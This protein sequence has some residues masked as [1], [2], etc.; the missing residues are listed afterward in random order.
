MKL[1]KYLC[2][3][4]ISGLLLSVYAF[5]APTTLSSYFAEKDITL[6][7]KADVGKYIL[8]GEF[9]GTDSRLGISYDTEYVYVAAILAEDYDSLS[10]TLGEKTVVYNIAD[11]TFDG[12]LSASTSAVSGDGLELKLSMG[13]FGMTFIPADM[14]Y[15]FGA[16]LTKGEKSVSLSETKAEFRY[17]NAIWY[18]NCED[19]ANKGSIDGASAS[20]AQNIYIGQSE[21]T[22][23]AY[24]FKMINNVNS[25][26]NI[27]NPLKGYTVG[28]AV[29][30]MNLKVNNLPDITSDNLR[31]WRGFVF[32][33][34][35]V[36]RRRFSLTADANGN[37]IG[38][39][40]R[41]SP[42]SN[43]GTSE[44]VDIGKN[45]GDAFKLTGRYN[46]DNDLA[47]Y[48]DDVLVHTFEKIDMPANY[49]KTVYI[50]EADYYNVKSGSIDVEM[51]DFAMC[52]PREGL[53]AVNFESIKGN[54]ISETDI[55][56]DLELYDSIT[57]LG[58]TY[59][60]TWKSSD[61]SIIT[62]DGKVVVIAA[63]AGKE[64]V[65]TAKVLFGETELTREIPLKISADLSAPMMYAY[66]KNET[67]TVDG[68][69]SDSVVFLNTELSGSDAAAGAVWTVDGIVFGINTGTVNASTVAVKLGGKS[70]TYSF[71]NN[72]F[73]ETVQDVSAAKGTGMVEMFIPYAAFDSEFS[74]GERTLPFAVS[75]SDGTN[76]YTAKEKFL[77][78][79]SAVMGS[80]DNCDKFE[81]NAYGTY[82]LYGAYSDIVRTQ[83]SGYYNFKHTST[84][85]AIYGFG[86]SNNGLRNAPFE[87]EVGLKVT[88][89]PVIS[90]EKLGAWR[91]LAFDLSDTASTRH[92]FSLTAS[93][94]GK[95]MF[96]ALY[97]D[98]GD[99]NGL[100][101][102]LDTGK[103]L[104]DSFN[105]RV[106][107]GTDGCPIIYID[108]RRVGSLPKV[109]YPAKNTHPYLEIN[110]AYCDASS[111]GIDVD[112]YD[113][114]L[115]RRKYLMDNLTFDD[116]KGNNPDADNVSMNLALPSSVKFADSGVEVPLTWTSSNE[117]YIGSDGV[118]TYSGESV[119]KT[120]TMTATAVSGGVTMT[121]SFDVTLK[122]ETVDKE[123]YF[124]FDDKN[125]YTGVLTKTNINFEY[126]FDKTENSI[127]LD[128]G[129]KTRIN[130]V[131]IIDSD[132]INKLHRS[133]VSLYVSDDNVN[134]TRIKD[135]DLFRT[136][137]KL[138]FAN[139]E[140]EARF[141]KV[142]CHIA[143]NESVSFKNSLD[144]II[145]ASYNDS[146]VGSGDGNFEKLGSVKLK[147]SADISDGTAYLTFEEMGIDTA[148]LKGDKSDIR[149]A[150]GERTLRHCVEDDG[151]YIRIPEAEAG[152]SVAVDIYGGNENAEN[153]SDADAVFEV[154]Y[155]NRT[156]QNLTDEEN[157]F[158]NVIST[159]RC[160]NGDILAI[161]SKGVVKSTL[162]MRRSTDGG[163]T[164]GEAELFRDNGTTADGFA[165]LV[166][167][168][169]IFCIFHM[170]PIPAVSY[171]TLNIAILVSD[172]NGYTWKNPNT[173]GTD[174]YFPVTGMHYTVTYCEGIKLSTFDGAD[175]DGIDYIFMYEMTS[176]N[177]YS[178]FAVG[179]LY[180][181]DAGK[182]WINSES[183][184]RFNVGDETANHETG[185]SE[186]SVVEL[187]DGTL[188]IYARVQYED[189][190]FLGTS[191]SKDHGVTWDEDCKLTTI[192]S[193]NTHPVLKK[194]KDSILLL[195]AGN[196]MEGGRSYFRAPMN[197]AYSKDDMKTWNAKLDIW[198]G[199]SEGSVADGKYKGVQ[200]KLI[201]DDYKGGDNIHIAWWKY[202]SL[203]NYGLLIEDADEYIFKTKGAAD[204]FETTN[205]LYEGW[206]T[207]A[208]NVSVSDEKA[209]DGSYSMK[210]EDV[211][212]KA[213]RVSRSIPELYK[214][215]ISFDI[216]LAD[217]S[218]YLYVELKSA[219]SL[220]H[221]T[222]DKLA[223]CVDK[224]GNLMAVN[225]AA[226][227]L[228]SSVAVLEK[229]EW[230][231][232]KV[233]FD[234][235]EG[236]A[237]LYLDGT[238]V[239]D[240]PINSGVYGGICTIQLSDSSAT[241]PAGLI[242][243][244]D[245][246]RAYEGVSFTLAQDEPE[247]KTTT[248]TVKLSREND[249]KPYADNLAKLNVYTD[250]TKATLV[251]TV[252]L[253]KTET[254]TSEVSAELTLAEGSYYAEITKNGY[255][256]FKCDVNVSIEG[257][258]LGEV[259][260]IPGDVKAS[261]SDEHG[262]GIVDIDD[263]IRVLRGFSAD[264]DNELRS[265]VD[266]NEDGIVN[267]GDIALIKKNYGKSFDAE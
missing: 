241:M 100:T 123:L 176:D 125:P 60:V 129:S 144:G 134:F 18:D 14:T 92:H 152:K 224:N 168:D 77:T 11:S 148:E 249:V 101:R 175:G 29:F 6:D 172:D 156:I 132:N 245:N 119:E 49:E 46:A 160:P 72:A 254:A 34:Q 246:F 170:F 171:Y 214:G 40:L 126:I 43:D 45:I 163:R 47:L 265:A 149:F 78:N 213:A 4:L 195:W 57:I 109:D 117:E 167:G 189:N 85:D 212:G 251:K 88:D 146:F 133:D 145:S 62:D 250:R 204:S 28:D 95:I 237:K 147:A 196:N 136:E 59:N 121:K 207:I 106:S 177:T 267:V 161:G 120:V 131:E 27:A 200:P 235:N 169:R 203:Q 230:Y 186:C 266:I 16:S 36:V 104:G 231:N 225:A 191:E 217:Y 256:T 257:I 79:V 174:P 154:V 118:L 228:G 229:D 234:L 96:N 159:V 138:I 20:N 227:T 67:V 263:F 39:V 99:T 182:T 208:G 142:H 155:G 107:V 190:V 87:L 238:E 139:F 150:I 7:G 26:T 54:N 33:L 130:T 193:S 44:C 248:V 21:T 64:V 48:I 25:F 165:F 206:S 52:T 114:G 12:G 222:G 199:T 103:K 94:D 181:R 35:T 198:S 37:I 83:N 63:N 113:I 15:T 216:N 244:V 111:G 236:Y 86:K 70:F 23:S 192:Y 91:G 89:L 180:S 183:V 38:S 17:A 115:S 164:W 162:T 3:M 239:A 82:S 2:A 127:G 262:D 205:V 69:L 51:L 143:V 102:S 137:N 157:D 32:D 187:S 259:T 184:I 9:P 221:Y 197:L 258:D 56:S 178:D 30:E 10:V 65:I 166:D 80:Y 151:A 22:A 261:Y 93:S 255:L 84:K 105:L 253:E 108:G 173:G 66:Y 19:F 124:R 53:S 226:K 81:S 219:L 211:S 185:V 97:Y 42:T 243:Y 31:A 153:I 74:A 128:L 98:A 90:P 158:N 112:I 179:A 215:E 122:F 73:T 61:T 201:F 242:A 252:V 110:L 220:D 247:E 13:E 68:T 188:K 116:I 55:I 24:S 240:L 209:T 202:N 8:S 5:A 75:V 264:A 210:I 41:Y 71:A 260:L 135:Y 50:L 233:D 1:L 194:Y 223:F 218:S 140:T 141:V 232:L 58:Q 76:T